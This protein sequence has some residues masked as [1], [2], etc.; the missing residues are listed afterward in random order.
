MRI[1]SNLLAPLGLCG[2]T[3]RLLPGDNTVSA[4]AWAKV[5]DS[6]AVQGYLASGEIVITEEAKAPESPKDDK[7]KGK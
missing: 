5:S 7:S 6:P 3:V 2:R 4:D 1:R